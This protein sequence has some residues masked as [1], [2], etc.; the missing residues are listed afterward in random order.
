MLARKCDNYVG[1]YRRHLVEQTKEAVRQ[2]HRR[3]QPLL[4][5]A[6]T[7]HRPASSD[8]VKD[9]LSS[10]AYHGNIAAIC[11]ACFARRRL[12]LSSARET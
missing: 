10:K 4:L 3:K 8:Q 12:E 2:S 11:L 7:A 5:S 1:Y 6:I 9:A